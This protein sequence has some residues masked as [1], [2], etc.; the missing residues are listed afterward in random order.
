MTKEEIDEASQHNEPTQ[1]VYE[2]PAEVVTG[3]TLMK[4]ARGEEL[5]IGDRECRYVSDLDGL[6][7]AGKSLYG[8]GFLLSSAAAE[9][10]SAAAEK[11]RA[12]AEK[13]RAQRIE[14]S[15]RER[16]MVEGLNK[17]DQ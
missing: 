17:S 8:G 12:A 3:A 5:K 11:A 6:K 14:L 16:K 2:M 7:E 15:A 4:I 13:A 9:K 10:A 1:V